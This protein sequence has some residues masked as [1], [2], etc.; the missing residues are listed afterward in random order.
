MKSQALTKYLAIDAQLRDLRSRD[1]GM[2]DEADDLYSD[3]AELWLDLSDAERAEA[4][5]IGEQ[6]DAA[7]VV[8][9]EVQLDVS[10]LKA[11]RAALAQE[12]SE[13]VYRSL[14]TRLGDM[15]KWCGLAPDLGTADLLT[16]GIQ[17]AYEPTSVS[18]WEGLKVTHDFDVMT[19]AV[20]QQILG[21][22]SAVPH[23]RHGLFSKKA[24]TKTMPAHLHRRFTCVY[25]SDEE[26]AANDDHRDPSTSSVRTITGSKRNDLAFS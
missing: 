17:T 25:D 13:S 11:W 7:E 4:N 10:A 21:A 12:A 15:S 5:A 22:V 24:L 3:G 19:V 18:L 14:L 20:G 23:I 1:L 26:R 2:S 6:R 8:H 9:V 16:E